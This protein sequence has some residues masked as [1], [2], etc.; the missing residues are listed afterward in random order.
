MKKHLK[1]QSY[2]QI[3]TIVNEEWNKV[4]DK[5]WKTYKKLSKKLG[6]DIQIV[7]DALGF[8]DY[9]SFQVDKNK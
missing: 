4:D 6:L 7:R 1:D 8:S 9:Y 2:D 5:N 3:I